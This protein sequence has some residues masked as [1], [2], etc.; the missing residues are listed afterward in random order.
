M[1]KKGFAAVTG[2]KIWYRVTGQ[3]KKAT[4][5]LCLHGGPGLASDYLKPLDKLSDERPV[6]R[7]DQLGSGRSERV[8]DTSLWT[9]E[10]YV[11]ELEEVRRIFK[12][13][14]VFILGH[15]WGSMIAVEYM[16]KMRPE[17]VEGLIL[18]GPCLSA[19]LWE[20]DQKRYVS[21]LPD[22]IRSA[23]EEAERKEEYDTKEYRK[24][25]MYYYKRH[26]CRLNPWPY[27]LI[28]TFVKMNTAIYKYMWG[29]SEFTV[30]G[31]LSNFERARDLAG[32]KVC[33]LFICGQFDEATPATTAYYQS[34]LPTSRIAVLEGASHMQM[35]EKKSEFLKIVRDFLKTKHIHEG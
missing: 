13:D 9:I 22:N 29:P 10:H 1:V 2:G 3:D 31:K 6:I 7:Y 8:K 14:R 18:S 30:R 35:L 26:V 20:K 27:S 5:L 4:P 11:N 25:A 23:I 33:V 15:S 17:G 12:L 21:E 16:L 32:I 28:M 34:M 19:S 24:A